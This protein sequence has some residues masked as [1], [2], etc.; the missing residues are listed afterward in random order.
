MN[1]LNISENTSLALKE[2]ENDLKGKFDWKFSSKDLRKST[3]HLLDLSGKM[4]RPTL[5]FIGAEAVGLNSMKYV[6]LAVAIEYLHISS[7]IHDDIVDRDT[8][9]RGMEAVHIKYGIE[10]AILAGDALIARAVFTSSPYGEDVIRKISDS[11]FVMCDGESM[12]FGVQNSTVQMNMKNYI[13]IAQKKT[14]SLISTSISIAAIHEKMCKSVIEKLSSA[15]EDLGI[16]FQVRDDVINS[17]GAIAL[18]KRPGKDDSKFN[19]PNIVTVLTKEGKGKREATEE[20]IDLMSSNVSRALEKL[21]DFEK[22][23]LIRE[24]L[25]NYFDSQQLRKYL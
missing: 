2:V 8:I 23:E 5:V 22:M 3:F 1:I 19:R 14:A 9:R 17:T 15:G 20:A 24:T 16:A 11:A 18:G 25:L 7:L 12:D 13:D 4:L 6:D 21:S 10:N